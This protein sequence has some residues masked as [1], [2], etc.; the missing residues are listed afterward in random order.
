MA[1]GDQRNLGGAASHRPLND[2]EPLLMVAGAFAAAPHA[3]TSWAMHAAPG[4]ICVYARVARLPR[5]G[6]GERVRQLHAAGLVK[7]LPQ[8]PT[9]SAPGLFDY[10]AERTALPY[11]QARPVPDEA[12]LSPDARL[13]FDLLVTV[14]DQGRACPSDRDLSALLGMKSSNQVGRLMAQLRGRHL[15]TTA[16]EGPGHALVRVVTIAETGAATWSPAG[17]RKGSR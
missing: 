8:R 16:L 15:I 7:M 9:E 4:L 10:R 1:R 13:L 11:C 14:A 2:E 17:K 12:G 6:V 3:V 5:G